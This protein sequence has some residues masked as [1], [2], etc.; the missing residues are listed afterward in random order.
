MAPKGPYRIDLA[1]IQNITAREKAALRR[2]WVNPLAIWLIR[3]SREKLDLISE[4]TGI[5]RR[6]LYY[7]KQWHPSPG[8]V[9]ILGAFRPP[10]QWPETLRPRFEAI[11]NE[12]NARKASEIERRPVKVEVPAEEV[13]VDPYEEVF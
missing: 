9:L 1:S 2:Y 13:W 7:A 11:R 3:Q 4:Q 6:T 5:A 8:T 10:D 12:V